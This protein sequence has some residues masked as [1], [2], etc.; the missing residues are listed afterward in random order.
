M[1]SGQATLGEEWAGKFAFQTASWREAQLKVVLLSKCFRTE[2]DLLL[3]A[4]SDMRGGKKSSA[5]IASL[6]PS[7]RAYLGT[8]IYIYCVSINLDNNVKIIIVLSNMYT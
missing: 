7:A 3:D 2:D 1:R 6:V 8:Y 5:A 4:L